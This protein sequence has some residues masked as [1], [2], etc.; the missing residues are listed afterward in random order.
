M[1]DE[2]SLLSRRETR[3]RERSGVESNLT[4]DDLL[5]AE[6]E[7]QLA[8][9]RTEEAL[10]PTPVTAVEAVV[11]PVEPVEPVV[12]ESETAEAPAA[13]AQ[14]SDS[15]VIPEPVEGSLPAAAVSQ[16]VEVVPVPLTPPAPGPEKVSD[17]VVTRKPRRSRKTAPKSSPVVP[18]TL[19]T[20][21]KTGVPR[22]RSNTKLGARIFS[23]IAIVFVAGIALASSIPAIAL[24][25][26]EQIALQAEMERIKFSGQIGDTQS[27]AANNNVSGTT[28]RDGVSVGANAA[29]AAGAYQAKKIKVSIPLAKNPSVWPF[30]HVHTS[31]SFGYRASILGSSPFHTGLDFDLP[32]GTNIQSIADGVVTY[33]EDPGPMCGSSIM[34]D[35]NINGTLF[36]TVYC[37]MV[38]RSTPLTVGQSVKAGDVVGQIGLTGITTGAHL[39]LEIR[40]NDVP[41]DPWAFL[42]QNSGNPPG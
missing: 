31:S 2:E 41:I 25:T 27:L 11:E 5:A 24:M 34:V 28:N 23:W 1:A 21:A 33:I 12:F 9:F 19:I 16:A 37:H 8:P 6:L 36:T 7:R 42:V 30:P 14:T 3:E 38:T 35:S 39:H 20:T 4:A 22:Q 29:A 32:Y 18:A 17:S 26:P 40:I 13:V 10:N 15:P